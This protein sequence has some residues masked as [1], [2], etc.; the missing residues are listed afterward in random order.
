MLRGMY[1]SASGMLLESLKSDIVA[2]NL[3][4]AST[5]GYKRQQVTVR[6]FPEMLLQRI[7]DAVQVGPTRIDPRPVIGR[8]GTGAAIDEI[9]LEMSTAPLR[10]TDNPL[11]FAIEGPGF[12][13]VLTE[14][15]EIAYTRDG[16]MRIDAEGFLRTHE[17]LLLLGVDGPIH[18]GQAVPAIDESGEV[19]VDG[20]AAGFVPLWEFAEPRALAR[21]G[22]NLLAPTE[23]SGD[24][25]MAQNSAIRQEYLEEANVNVVREMVDLITVQRAYEANQKMIQVQDETLGRLINDAATLA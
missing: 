2:N 5:H 23:G 8:L 6:S 10:L 21:L 19:W 15:G 3:A 12:F 18:V 22:G 24:P 25:V 4:N 17:G 13:A 11:D 9:A 1:T 14:A 7:N 20:E 16:R